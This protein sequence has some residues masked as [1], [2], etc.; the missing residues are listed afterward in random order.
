MVAITSRKW[1]SMSR[2]AP[3][4]PA[5]PWWIIILAFG[6]ASL[7][8][9]APPQ[10]IMAAADIPIPTQTVETSHRVLCMTS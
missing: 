3:R 4:A 1:I 2:G 8:P 5:E 9:G 6:V 10:R 7:L